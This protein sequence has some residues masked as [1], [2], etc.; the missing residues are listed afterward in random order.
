MP[1]P[2]EHSRTPSTQPSAFSRA[3]WGPN[4]PP[5]HILGRNSWW[6]QCPEED[7]HDDGCWGHIAPIRTPVEIPPPN[8]RISR[9]YMQKIASG[10]QPVYDDRWLAFM[11]DDCLF[12][13]RSWTGHG[14]YE[15][16]FA[17]KGA[18]FVPVSARIEGGSRYRGDS[19][20]QDFDP[21]EERNLLRDLIVG[22][23]DRAR[24]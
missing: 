3:L 19:G 7:G 18:G 15:V 11:E 24:A 22:L 14:I 5:A 6:E 2:E 17:A 8:M 20:S 12:L 4:G 16:T 21:V 23:W 9:D 13:H 1:Q 10:Y